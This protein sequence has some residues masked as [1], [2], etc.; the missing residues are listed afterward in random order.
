MNDQY[1]IYA[2]WVE[3]RAKMNDTLLRMIELYHREDL[4]HIIEYEYR[5]TTRQNDEISLTDENVQRT[6]IRNKTAISILTFHYR[7]PNLRRQRDDDGVFA[8]V[9]LMSAT[10]TAA[11][12]CRLQLHHRR[13]VPIVST[14]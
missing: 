12:R 1:S 11:A 7:R 13:C 8:A 4:H 10:D 5:H 2:I 6:M 3:H 14:S 9:I